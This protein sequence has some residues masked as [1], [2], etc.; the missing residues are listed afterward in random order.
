[1][2]GTAIEAHLEQCVKILKRLK[3]FTFSVK[4]GIICR[5]SPKV[6]LF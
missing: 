2:G 5:H 4:T 1:M 3:Y 6:F